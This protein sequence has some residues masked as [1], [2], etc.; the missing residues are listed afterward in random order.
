MTGWRR[1]VALVW[2]ALLGLPALALGRELLRHPGAWSA[3]SEAPRLLALAKNTFFLVGGTLALTVPAGVTLALLLERCD[4]PG[5]RL[6]R[7]LVVL[8]LFV[9][10]PLQASAWQAALGGGGWLPLPVWRTVAPDDPDFVPGGISWKPWALG[11]PAAIWV[12]AAA[13]LPWVVWLA[14][15]GLL[16]VERPLEEDALVNG[17]VWAAVWRVTLPRAGPAIAAAAAWVAIQTAT[18]ITVTDMMQVRTFAEEVYTQFA[19]PDAGGP[20]SHDVL[21]RAVVVALPPALLTALL[22]ALA[23][24]RWEKRLPPL[25]GAPRPP[26]VIPL[27]SWRWPVFAMVLLVV[28]VL[29]GIP[30][31][32]LVWKTGQ[33]PPG[34]SWSTAVF[35]V[36]LAGAFRSQFWLILTSLVWAALTGLGVAALA[37]ASCWLARDRRWLRLSFLVLLALAWTLPGPVMGIG[38][39]ESINILMDAEDAASAGRVQVFQA[40]LYNGPS[41]LPVIWATAVRFLP[42]AVAILWP[43]VRLI[44]REFFEAART[45]GA[46]PAGELWHAVL[47]LA[48]PAAVQSAL[49]VTALSLGELSAGKLVETPGGQTLAH[50]IF[51]QM[52]YG[53]ANHLAALCLLLL[54]AVAVPGIVWELLRGWFGERST[55]G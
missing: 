13:G 20:V 11:L 30:V 39:K 53:V 3:W 25:A 38:L 26:V 22:I 18:E 28:G 32:S 12:H 16:A 9:P 27:R 19:R 17:G 54:A 6:F 35:R 4:L 1:T 5:R 55:H 52:H 21:A 50:E 36:Q 44:P 15:R 46:T 42:C 37:L 48:L 14:G 41:P 2:L 33:V 8:M 10:L 51:T 24:S 47:P 23:A 40:A 49:A 29:A 43:T 45:D 31:G 34:T 7:R